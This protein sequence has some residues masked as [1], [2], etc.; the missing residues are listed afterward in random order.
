MKKRTKQAKAMQKIEPTSARKARP[1]A[2]FGVSVA[3]IIGVAIAACATTD[4]LHGHVRIDRRI[5]SAS[6][7]VPDQNGKTSPAPIAPNY[8]ATLESKYGPAAKSQAVAEA[9]RSAQSDSNAKTIAADRYEALQHGNWA[10]GTDPMQAVLRGYVPPG[11]SQQ[12]AA[13]LYNALPRNARIPAMPQP[14][15]PDRIAAM[16][17]EPLDPTASLPGGLSQADVQAAN[18]QMFEGYMRDRFGPVSVPPLHRGHNY[19]PEPN[20]GKMATAK[21]HQGSIREMTDSS[22]N[23]VY[24]QT[25]DPFGNPTQLQGSGPQPDFGYQGYYVHQRSGLNL[26]TYRA[27]NPKLGRW[28]SRDPIAD[29]TFHM[30]PREP[31]TTDPAS[32]A[33]MTP[34]MQVLAAITPRTA[35]HQPDNNLYTY[36]LNDP[37][38]RADPSGLKADKERCVPC[39]KNCDNPYNITIPDTCIEATRTGRNP[40]G[41]PVT[42]VTIYFQ[43]ANGSIYQAVSYG[44]ADKRQKQGLPTC[45]WQKTQ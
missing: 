29:P 7:P 20:I 37:I 33:Q 9:I 25:Y 35:S 27:Y 1:L 6:S 40:Q 17:G 31:Q 36:V 45:Y 38:N 32:M 13:M 3:L 11:M 4:L 12:Q 5:Q 28:L 23:I 21:D 42:Y 39:P 44:D 2:V 10:P 26:A 18:Q 41:E 34:A 22:G 24:Q 43:T 19:A 30:M 16:A 14:M 8:A 15:T